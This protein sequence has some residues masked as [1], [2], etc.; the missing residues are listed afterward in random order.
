MTG[1]LIYEPRGRAREYAALACNIYKGCDHGCIYCYAPGATRVAIETFVN[2]KP[3]EDFAA[4][5]EHEAA[6]M[7]AAKLHGQVLLCFTCDPYQVLDVTEQTTS[8]AIDIL[9]CY[10]FS[11]CILTKGGSRALSDIGLFH[12]DDAFATTLTFTGD[13]EHWK[14]WEP[15]ASMPQD[16]IA[17]IKTFHDYDIPTWVSLEPTIEP[18]ESLE[19]IRRTH[20]FTDLFKVGKL[21]YHPH[22]KTIDW[23]KFGHDAIRLLESLG[24]HRQMNP[25]AVQ[26]AN[27]SNKQYYIKR[28]LVQL[29]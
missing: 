1:T 16:R 22:A 15:H 13:D 14:V 9:H 23:R 6:K 25:D 26:S 20:E 11:V 18:A 3:R 21:N 29:L 8:K 27:S 7:Y 17:T 10:G 28:D 12:S 5:L 2:S 24:Y 4:K 19:L